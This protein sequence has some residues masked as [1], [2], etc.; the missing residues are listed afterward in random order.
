MTRSRECKDGK[1]LDVRGDSNVGIDE[2]PVQHSPDYDAKILAFL[3]D[4]F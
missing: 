4:I 2:K 1:F 3:L